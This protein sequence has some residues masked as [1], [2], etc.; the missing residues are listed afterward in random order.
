MMGSLVSY[1][2]KRLRRGSHRTTQESV[3]IHELLVLLPLFG[4]S[5]SLREGA[6]KCVRVHVCV[7]IV[8]LP[9]HG[10]G[11]EVLAD[12]YA[13]LCLCVDACMDACVL[14]GVCACVCVCVGSSSA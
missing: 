2:A 6:T 8:C 3:C 9:I 4:H 12:I 10:C 14:V 11:F 13:F 1:E 5:I 7:C